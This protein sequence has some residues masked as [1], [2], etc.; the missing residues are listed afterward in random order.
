MFKYK[1]NKDFERSLKQSGFAIIK[2]HQISPKLIDSVY[3]EWEIF[4]NNPKKFQYLKN[5][6]HKAVF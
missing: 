4:F 6:N 1:A 2:D 5:Q 3:A